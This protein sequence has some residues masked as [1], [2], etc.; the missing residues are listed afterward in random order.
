MA[1]QMI[2]SRTIEKNCERGKNIK[3]KTSKDRHK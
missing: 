1:A 2:D 3:E